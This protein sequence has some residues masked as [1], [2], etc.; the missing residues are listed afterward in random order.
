MR[1]I[2]IKEY[3]EMALESMVAI[4]K[5]GSYMCTRENLEEALKTVFKWYERTYWQQRI[6]KIEV[7]T[8]V[9]ET[10]GYEHISK[11]VLF[12]EESSY[13]WCK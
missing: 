2:A 7:R 6:D 5:N 8:I 10:N 1:P 13:F 9:I 12:A 4:V 3:K 11:E